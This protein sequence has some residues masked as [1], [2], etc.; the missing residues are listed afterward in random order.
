MTNNYNKYLYGIGFV[1][2]GIGSIYIYIRSL[3]YI[4]AFEAAKL[5]FIEEK[6]NK[7]N[8]YILIMK[9]IGITMLTTLLGFSLYKLKITCD[10]LLK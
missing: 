3:E 2:I 1:G 10:K 4:R 8:E 7:K 6:E 5:K 9:T